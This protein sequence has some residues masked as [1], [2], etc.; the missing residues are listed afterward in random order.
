MR[1]Q[2]QAPRGD[3][4]GGIPIGRFDPGDPPEEI[5]AGWEAAREGDATGAA[6]H[7][8]VSDQD[9]AV[10]GAF[11][12]DEPEPFSGIA[13]PPGAC[14]AC[15]AEVERRERA[16]V[17][18]ADAEY[19]AHL[20]AKYVD[21]KLARYINGLPDPGRHSEHD[22]ERGYGNGWHDALQEILRVLERPARELEPAPAREVS[23]AEADLAYDAHRERERRRG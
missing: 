4:E 10:C 12:A 3:D 8:G 6:F 7:Y 20:E 16:E 17:A 14:R 5:H 19:Q 13:L 9:H 1:G 23:D 22:Y 15:A 11:R 2:R 18:A 21:A